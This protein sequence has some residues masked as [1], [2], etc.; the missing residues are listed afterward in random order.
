MD[1]NRIE[2]DIRRWHV[3]MKEM[4]RVMGA[5]DAVL[6]LR[7]ES[8]FYNAVWRL[9]EGYIAGLEAQ[10]G[11]GGWL[12]WWWTECELGAK[13]MNASPGGSKR[14]R[15]IATINNFVNLVL[16]DLAHAEKSNG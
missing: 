13:P 5:M 1:A 3:A 8:A 9:C 4:D 12:D 10:H 6:D 16:D 11:I 14:L 15:K 2:A 7:P